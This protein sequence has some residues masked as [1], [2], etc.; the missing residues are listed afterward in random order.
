MDNYRASMTE[1]YLGNAVGLAR[2]HIIEGG[3]DAS[4][5]EAMKNN[6][7]TRGIEVDLKRVDSIRYSESD[8]KD[9]LEIANGDWTDIETI[10]NIY[11]KMYEMKGKDFDE[12]ALFGK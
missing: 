7:I 1:H 3:H 12:E 5:L 2:M 11:R 8:L 6:F 10:K 9:V 4:F